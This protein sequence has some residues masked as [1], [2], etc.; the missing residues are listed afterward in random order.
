MSVII[1]AVLVLTFRDEALDRLIFAL[2][3]IDSLGGRAA[4]VFFGAYVIAIICF[5]P[6]SPFLITGGALFG[7]ALG[8][9]L[10]LLANL[11]G[12]SISFWLARTRLRVALLRRFRHFEVLRSL[13]RA[14]REDGLRTVL[15][16]RSVPVL[17]S[18][19]INYGLGL[20][21]ARYRDY[22]LGIVSAVP[23]FLMYVYYGK[24]AGELLVLLRGDGPEHGWPYYAVLVLGLT[25]AVAVTFLLSRRTRRIMDSGISDPS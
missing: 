2:D 10:G 23:M 24:V 18:W 12:G 16:I 9:S 7:L 21:P 5:V 17:P 22:L 25:A 19:S 1:V 14:I 13:D 15:L 3:W 11:V 6:A 20:S 4:F 8:T